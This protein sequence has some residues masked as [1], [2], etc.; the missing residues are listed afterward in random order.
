MLEGGWMGQKHKVN[1]KFCIITW[2]WKA[3]LTGYCSEKEKS[4]KWRGNPRLVCF[5]FN[6][7][8]Q[9]K[10]DNAQSFSALEYEGFYNY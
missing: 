1:L 10:D 3:P 7:D 2:V 8:L 5:L 6:C 4:H 9:W